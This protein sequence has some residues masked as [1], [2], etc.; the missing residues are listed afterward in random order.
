MIMQNPNIEIK[1]WFINRLRT[2]TSLVVYDGGNIPPDT[3]NEYVTI[4]GR[5]AG[6]EQGKTGYTSECTII[7]NIVAK[8][9]NF[10]YDRTE[11]ISNLILSG[12]NS[13][14]AIVLPTGWS[15]TRLYVGGLT[16]LDSLNPLDNVFQTV[17][18]YSLIITQTQ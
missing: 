18:T 3:G 14:T 7:C 8:S 12:I 1:K 4:T 16:N 15:A 5:Q 11:A 13:D 2:D 17:I 9:S 10:G 6:Q